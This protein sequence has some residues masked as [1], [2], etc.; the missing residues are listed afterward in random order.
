MVGPDRARGMF[1]LTLDAMRLLEGLIAEEA[2]DCD[3]AHRGAVTL[4]ASRAT[5]GPGAESAGSFA[6]SWVT[7]PSC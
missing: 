6:R 5:S 3:F 7:R 4:A 2:I 1:Q